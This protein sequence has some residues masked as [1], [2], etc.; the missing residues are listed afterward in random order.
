MSVKMCA[1][2]IDAEY[3][4]IFFKNTAFRKV[5][6]LEQLHINKDAKYGNK[7]IKINFHCAPKARL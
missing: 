7:S 2:I 6:L 3:S 4:K 5:L 1:V